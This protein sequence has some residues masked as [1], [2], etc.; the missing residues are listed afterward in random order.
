MCTM[1]IAAQPPAFKS[2]SLIYRSSF[3]VW[4]IK[5]YNQQKNFLYTQVRQD[6]VYFTDDGVMHI[7]NKH[8]AKS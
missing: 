6:T 5:L 3:Q 4:G 2:S 7:T 1:Q 8:M